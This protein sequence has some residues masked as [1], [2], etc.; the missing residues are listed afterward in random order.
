MISTSVASD[1]CILRRISSQ[2]E[3]L[4]PSQSIERNKRGFTDINALK[5]TLKASIDNSSNCVFLAVHKIRIWGQPSDFSALWTAGKLA[6]PHFDYSSCGRWKEL[7]RL[8]VCSRRCP[9]LHIHQ[10]KHHGVAWL[11]P[12]I[13]PALMETPSNRHWAEMLDS[14]KELHI[15]STTESISKQSACRW[16]TGCLQAQK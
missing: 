13:L 1:T 7:W 10:P 2:K 16:K 6:E 9:F 3:G 15:N 4:Q 8:L 11:A 5:K 12:A 14:Y